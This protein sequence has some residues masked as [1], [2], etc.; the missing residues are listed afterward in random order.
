MDIMP[1]H[2]HTALEV[3]YLGIVLSLKLKHISHMQRSILHNM[4]SVLRRWDLK[5]RSIC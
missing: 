5:L 1:C 4:H 3:P 2:G